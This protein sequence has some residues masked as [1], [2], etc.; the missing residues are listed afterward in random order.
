MPLLTRDMYFKGRNRKFS[1][2]LTDELKINADKIIARS[3]ELLNRIGIGK[4]YVTSGWRPKSINAQVG[5][6][7]NSQHI[8]C[9]AID[10][11]DPTGIMGKWCSEN[12][13]SLAEIG[14][15]MESLV[16]TH[17]SE[18]KREWWVHLQSVAPKS[19]NRIFM[20]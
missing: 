2:D 14:L 1:Q 10:I 18:D 6:S 8:Y 12:I 7:L 9:N 20:P 4:C 15:W 11:S 16:A 19:G 13:E 3:S 17:K 5:G